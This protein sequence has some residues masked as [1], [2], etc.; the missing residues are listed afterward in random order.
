M[1]R[2]TPNNGTYA[3]KKTVTE[4]EK[5]KLEKQTRKIVVHL[6]NSLG[7]LKFLMYDNLSVMEQ[8]VQGTTLN[9]IG[10]HDNLSLMEQI[11][12]G[13]SPQLRFQSVET[14]T[15]SATSTLICF[16]PWQLW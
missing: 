8:I 16:T 6:Q 5:N 12:Q 14:I 2:N 1:T 10:R 11:V 13:T 9:A 7:G 4:E 15:Q 3:F